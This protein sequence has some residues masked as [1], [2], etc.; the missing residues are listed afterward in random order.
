MADKSLKK[1]PHMSK[2]AAIGFPYSEMQQGT[3]FQAQVIRATEETLEILRQSPSK[4]PDAPRVNIRIDPALAHE[5][6]TAIY[7]LD[8]AAQMRCNDLG[9]SLP[10]VGMIDEDLSHYG[11]LCN[12]H[13]LPRSKR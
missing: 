4:L 11:L 6:N 3:N 7:Y 9:L 2:Y 10:V 8:E 12:L 13:Y 1:G 5:R